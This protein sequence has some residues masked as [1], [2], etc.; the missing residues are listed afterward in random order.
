MTL[1]RFHIRDA[2]GLIKD[3]QGINLPNLASAFYRALCIAKEFSAEAAIHGGMRFEIAD[4]TRRTVLTVPICDL[5]PSKRPVARA[6][7][8]LKAHA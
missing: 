7:V 8:H 1:Y 4:S 6:R 5:R 2:S 3:S